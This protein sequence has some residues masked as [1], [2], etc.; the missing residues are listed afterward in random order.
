MKIMTIVTTRSEIIKLSL[1]I[2]KLDSYCNHIVVYIGQNDPGDP[3]FSCFKDLN[4]REPDY[5][6]GIRADS[7]GEQ[8]N[9]ILTEAEKVIIKEKPDRML[10]SGSANGGLVSII[11]KRMGITIFHMEA[12]NRYY[13]THI[14]EEA[15]R[16]IIDHSST[17]LLTY[18]QRSKENLFKEGINNNRIHI[19]GHPIYEVLTH[20]AKEIDVSKVLDQLGLKP[21]KYFLFTMHQEENVDDEYKLKSTFTGLDRINIEYSLPIICSLPQRTRDKIKKCNLAIPNK[22]IRLLEP[23]SF[24]DFVHLEKNATCVITDS[25]TVQEECCILGTPNITIRDVTEKPETIECGSTM[26]ASTSPKIM[27]K[28]VEITLKEKHQWTP[29][30]EYLESNV[31]S[32]VVKMILGYLT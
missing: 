5:R 9:K 29:P 19:T 30:Q 25:G 6:L 21:K 14:P 4:L 22:D 1:I 13:N 7:N 10:I 20:Y 24:F 15:N 17:I 3:S 32:K 2:R 27:I 12:G 26:L 8:I 16:I 23:F 11:A 31:S 18:S 28:S